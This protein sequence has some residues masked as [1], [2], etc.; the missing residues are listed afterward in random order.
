MQALRAEWQ[1]TG[2]RRR[3]GRQVARPDQRTGLSFTNSEGGRVTT[4]TQ[5]RLRL[6][7]RLK[8][9]LRLRLKLKLRLRLKLKL[10]LRLKLKLRLR[11]VLGLR[12][13]LVLGLR[14]RRS[15]EAGAEAERKRR[16]GWQ[17]RLGWRRRGRRPG[18]G[19][20]A[21]HGLPELWVALG[22]VDARA[23]RQ[24]ERSARRQP[25]KRTLQ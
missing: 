10:R 14:R 2:S 6:R 8:L 5:T 16:L 13:R 7:L 25:C 1:E 23:L 20:M 11:L 24:D 21:G 17:R 19:M 22:E 9:R 12:L 4:V 18:G 3:P 15:R